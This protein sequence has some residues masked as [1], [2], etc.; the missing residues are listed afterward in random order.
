MCTYLTGVCPLTHV[1]CGWEGHLPCG[2]QD[3]VHIAH[4]FTVLQT[5]VYV[6]HCK[7]VPLEGRG[8]GKG[9]GKGRREGRRE[10]EEGRGGGK[11]GGKG[12][13]EGEEGREEGRGGVVGVRRS[14]E[15]Q[16]GET[17]VH[18]GVSDNHHGDIA[19]LSFHYKIRNSSS[20]EAG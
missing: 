18:I 10:G 17:S 16:E 7:H 15:E 20:T 12:R 6:R 13:R 5:I 3:S 9:G 2:G 14:E 19:S 1:I 4:H 8:G 11:G